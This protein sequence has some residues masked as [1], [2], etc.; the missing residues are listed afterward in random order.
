[1]EKMGD[2]MVP[3]IYLAYWTRLRVFKGLGKQVCRRARGARFNWR[4]LAIYGEGV[5]TLK[6]PGQQTLGLL[7]VCCPSYAQVLWFHCRGK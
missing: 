6:L 5:S 3:Q 2:L 7:K 4:N 1:M